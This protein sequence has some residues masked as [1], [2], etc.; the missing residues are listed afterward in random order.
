MMDS[1]TRGSRF[2]FLAFRE[3]SL[4]DSAYSLSLSGYYYTRIFNEYREQRLV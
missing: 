1:P 2:V 3:P 4:F